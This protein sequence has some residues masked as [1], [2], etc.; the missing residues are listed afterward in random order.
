M[1]AIVVLVLVSAMVGVVGW[2]LL[3]ASREAEER[4]EE[5]QRDKRARRE[6][7]RLVEESKQAEQ[8][9]RRTEQ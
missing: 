8:Q 3:I 5:I 7:A 4:W 6:L 2:S 9:R 1:T